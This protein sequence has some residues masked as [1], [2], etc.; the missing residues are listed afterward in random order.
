MGHT[1]M[2]K[3]IVSSILLLSLAAWAVE[4][5]SPPADI[6]LTGQYVWKSDPQ[7][8]GD[9]KAVFTHKAGDEY[10]VSFHF[11]FQGGEYTY[12]GSAKGK[13]DNGA[14]AGEVKDQTGRRTFVFEGTSAAGKFKGTHAEIG[15]RDKRE[16]TGTITLAKK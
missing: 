16:D 2:R 9:V 1:T 8:P 10:N 13:L 14:L 4:P 12:T 7:N 11:K 5:I 15:R 6:S 3:A